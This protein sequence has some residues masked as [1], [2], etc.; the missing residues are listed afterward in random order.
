MA[1]SWTNH[2]P[3]WLL[4]LGL[5]HNPSTRS[6]SLWV[7][8]FFTPFCSFLWLYSKR[9]Q[10]TQNH[11][12]PFGCAKL[13]SRGYAGVGPCFHLPGFQFG[14]GFLRNSHFLQRGATYFK[15]HSRSFRRLQEGLGP[16]L[17]ALPEGQNCLKAS[18]RLFKREGPKQ[19]PRTP[20]GV[21]TFWEKRVFVEM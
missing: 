14:I 19:D 2:Q 5:K 1:S 16:V 6:K 11:L 4:V 20:R 3:K 21:A 17:R 13:N 9:K 18:T 12:G 15:K 10:D 7:S 8:V